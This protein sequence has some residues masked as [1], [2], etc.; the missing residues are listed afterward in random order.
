MPDDTILCDILEGSVIYQKKNECINLNAERNAYQIAEI[1][2]F[3]DIIEHKMPN[4]ST[5][6]QAYAVLKLSKGL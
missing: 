1:K 6:E 2:H 4:D 3:F 5:A